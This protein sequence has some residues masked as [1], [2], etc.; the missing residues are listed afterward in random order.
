MSAFPS[1]SINLNA[2]CLTVSITL[3][4]GHRP[5]YIKLHVSRTSAQHHRECVHMGL[6]ANVTEHIGA[7]GALVVIVMICLQMPNP[8]YFVFTLP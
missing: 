3:S 1:E 8:R 6:V 2:Q 5:S 4:H 7:S